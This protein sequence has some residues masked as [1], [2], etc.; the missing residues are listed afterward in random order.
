MFESTRLGH[1]LLLSGVTLLITHTHK[2]S[3]LKKSINNVFCESGGV[4]FSQKKPKTTT[5]GGKGYLSFGLKT[6][7]S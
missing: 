2:I 6:F 7:I 1:I 4:D 5:L 3:L